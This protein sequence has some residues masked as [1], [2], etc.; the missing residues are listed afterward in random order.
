V[1]SPGLRRTVSKEPGAS[2][3]CPCHFRYELQ[4]KGIR[5]GCTSPWGGMSKRL[6]PRPGNVRPGTAGTDEE[7]RTSQALNGSGSRSSSGTSTPTLNGQRTSLGESTP[8]N[9]QRTLQALPPHPLLAARSNGGSGAST[10]MARPNSM[11][12]LQG[13]AQKKREPGPEDA[14]DEQRRR[15]EEEE[16]RKQQV[17]ARR[18]PGP[19]SEF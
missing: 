9:G 16:R 5:D 4:K 14:A 3:L 7:P 17:R 19:R 11:P 12:P 15:Q 1:C 18:G 2:H 13:L 10:P 6:P 8:T